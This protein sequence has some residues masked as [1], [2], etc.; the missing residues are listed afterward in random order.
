GGIIIGG[1]TSTTAAAAL[2]SA[3]P[4]NAAGAR[5]ARN[6]FTFADTL[7]VSRGKHQF[8]VGTWFQ[9]I[10]DNEDTASRRLGV[11]NFTNLTQF[12]QGTLSST[13]G[14]QVVPKTTELGFRS[15]FGAWFAE[16]SI[17]LRRNLTVRAGL[18]HEFTNGWNEKYGRAANY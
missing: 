11:A 18:R 9:K 7:Q 6:L 10:Q 8:S 16:D 1:T 12:L 5:N 4:N 14:F 17:R 15:W 3:G 13:T 2:T